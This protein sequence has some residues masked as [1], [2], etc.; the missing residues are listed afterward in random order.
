MRRILVVS[1]LCLIGPTAWPQEPEIPLYPR[2]K[3]ETTKGDFVLQLNGHRAPRSVSNFIDYVRSG[4]YEGTVFHR[5]IDGFMIQGGGYTVEL[6]EKEV[7]EA[8]AN[9]SGN[10]LQNRRGTIAMARTNKPHS[11]NAQ[12]FINLVDNSR[13][14]PSA[15]RWG[16]AVFG[17]VIEGMEIVD[18]IG[19]SPT[20][21]G[22]SFPTDVPQVPV[23]VDKVSLLEDENSD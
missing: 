11:A 1:L 22:G 13:L 16:Y 18:R 15:T 19:T 17:E 21:P 9:E 5:V 7:N 10:G 6:K 8:I 14:D 23:I 20:G 4:Y 2:V 12:F 3:V